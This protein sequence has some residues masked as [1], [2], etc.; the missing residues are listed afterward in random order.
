MQMD[1]EWMEVFVQTLRGGELHQN[2]RVPIVPP[3]SARP[4]KVL[5][6]NGWQP[7]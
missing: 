6:P 2:T 7:G 3:P 5:I 1:F 4:K